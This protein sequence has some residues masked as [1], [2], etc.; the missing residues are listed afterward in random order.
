MKEKINQFIDKIS[1]FLAYRKGLLPF[2]G[3]LFI[4]LNWI[5]QFIPNPNWLI[6]SDTFLHVGTI[7]AIVGLMVAWAL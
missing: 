2:V 7:L 6:T 3:I 5:M 1:E 4:S